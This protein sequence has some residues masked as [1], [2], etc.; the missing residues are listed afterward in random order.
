MIAVLFTKYRSEDQIKKKVVGGARVTC[1][2]QERSIQG[3]VGI[4]DGNIHLEDLGVDGRII[5]KWIF[6]RW[7]W[8]A[9]TGSICLRDSWRAF[10]NVVMNLPVP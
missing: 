2:T 1:R 3:L 5:L 8:D 9:C 6:G 4:P 10:V 7:D